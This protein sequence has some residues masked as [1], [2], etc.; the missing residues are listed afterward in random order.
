VKTADLDQ[1]GFPELIFANSN[2]N[3]GEWRIDSTLYWGSASGDSETDSTA[4][5]TRWSW[6]RIIGDYNGDGWDDIAF[7]SGWGG[8][9]CEG[10][11][12]VYYRDAGSFDPADVDELDGSSGTTISGIYWGHA[13]GLGQCSPTGGTDDVGDGRGAWAASSEESGAARRDCR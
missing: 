13:G 10:P 6:G 11:S 5:P 8:G 2:D 12:S 1:D 3:T 7:S 9:G 4:L